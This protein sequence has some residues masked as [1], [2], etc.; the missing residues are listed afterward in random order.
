MLASGLPSPLARLY[1]TAMQPGI[2]VLDAVDD[3]GPWPDDDTAAIVACGQC[4]AINPRLEDDGLRADVLAM[5]LAVTW[6]MSPREAGRAE[7][8]RAAGGLVL[9]S[10][11]RAAE[12]APG[13]GRLA[14]VIAREHGRD[15]TAAAFGYTVAVL[16]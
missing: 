12:P 3:D 7:D 13:P 6:F 10:R 16:E 9:I 11:T 15:T 2:V 14:A 1:S 4:V 8:I 5:A